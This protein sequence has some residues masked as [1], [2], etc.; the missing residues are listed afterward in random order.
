MKFTQFIGGSY[1]VLGSSFS[2]ERCIN[3]YPILSENP[4]GTKS[5]K[6]LRSVAG[7]EEAYTVGT[8]AMRG[9]K[10]CAN[11]RA[12]VVSGGAFYEINSNGT[13]TNKGTVANIAGFVSMAENGTE[14]CIVDGANGYI[15][16][17]DDDT[18]EQITAEGFQDNPLS[19]TFQ[20]GYF[21]VAY[22][23]SNAFGISGIYDGLTWDALDYAN[24][25]TSAD[26]NLA[27]V[28]NSGLLFVM[29]SLGTDIYQNTGNADFPF[30][31]VTGGYIPIGLA[32]THSV[33]RFDTGMFWLTVDEW[34]RGQVVQASG[35]NTKKISNQWVDKL[36][37]DS[38]DLSQSFAYCYH[39]DGNAFYVLN[40]S[41]INTTLVYELTSG[42]W[43]ERQYFDSVNGIY[44]QHRGC[45]SFNFNQATYICDSVSNKI[46]H[47]SNDIYD[48]DGDEIHRI[49]IS[50]I[51]SNEK[52]MG[53]HNSFELDMETGIGL[54]DGDT[55]D[56]S[57][58][59]IMQYSDDGGKTWSNELWRSVGKLGEYKS[60]VAW[61]R[62][63]S[64]RDR[65][66]KTVY[67]A[68]TKYQINDAYINNV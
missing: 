17:M 61:H 51:I 15:Y 50:P 32:A 30:E 14:V 22:G 31:R 60:R 53:S 41:G 63:G 10:T 62:L 55:Q 67:T 39:E 43:H 49:R 9:A 45:F 35:M 37:N 7:Y 4:D 36:I 8:G 52:M 40:V 46:Y 33:V 34:G 12:F 23:G 29:G 11:G 6:A 47:Q 66:Y 28:A 64:A 48:F 27:V 57:P 59:I 26:N 54:S 2:P 5:P 38:S 44:R 25:T 16:N 68:A 18:F 3:Q 21:I 24:A 42:I 13:T 19:V 1:A 58:E 65:V 20:D 56:V